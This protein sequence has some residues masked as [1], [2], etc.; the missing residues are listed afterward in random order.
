MELENEASKLSEYI[1]ELKESGDFEY[2]EKGIQDEHLGAIIADAILQ[3]G[4]DYK[5]YVLPRVI[6]IKTMFPDHT[7]VSSLKE[8]SSS[9]AEGIRQF[10]N[11][12][13][14]KEQER[15]AATISFFNDEGIETFS[16]LRKWLSKDKNRDKLITDSGIQ[17]IRERTADYFRVLVRLPNAVKVD[18]RI[19]KFLFNAGITKYKYSYKE[20]RAIVEI[21]A[22]FLKIKPI[23]LDYS[24]WEYK[25]KD[26]QKQRE[27]ATMPKNSKRLPLTKAK[28]FG[29]KRFTEEIN[30]ITSEIP[31]LLE[32][33]NKNYTPGSNSVDLIKRG[34]YVELYYTNDCWDK[35]KK[36]CWPN[37]NL[38]VGLHEI[39]RSRSAV[40]RFDNK[41]RDG[42]GTLKFEW[43][44]SD[45]E[46]ESVLN[47]QHQ[48]QGA[49]VKGKV[50]KHNTTLSITITDEEAKQLEALAIKFDTT[51]EKL[52]K[53][54]IIERLPETKL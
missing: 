25:S 22:G 18:T 19:T 43:P 28:K 20:K 51:S 9:N 8:F 33:Y 47:P 36:S 30:W 5:K 32:K 3:A 41:V 48:K 12:N 16:D 37:G 49:N 26:N 1:S 2:I 17:G 24:I 13:G 54:W 11:W 40:K 29:E 44:L 53:H 31:K 14:R 52:A 10:L 42:G 45:T 34:K 46:W 38:N 39:K 35:F 7:N 23:D 27:V 6:R 15:F 4:H 50:N 21:A